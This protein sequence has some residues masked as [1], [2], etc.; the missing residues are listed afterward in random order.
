MAREVWRDA[1]FVLEMITVYE[2]RLIVDI[3]ES[4]GTG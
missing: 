3:T 4:T 1:A 2:N